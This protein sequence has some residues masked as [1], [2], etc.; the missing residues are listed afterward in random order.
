MVVTNY[1]N[2]GDPP[3]THNWN[4]ECGVYWDQNSPM[5]LT[6]L[7]TPADAQERLIFGTQKNTNEQIWEDSLTLHHHLK[8]VPRL[9]G[10]N[11]I[12]PDVSK[13]ETPLEICLE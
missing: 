4:D 12:C 13:E 8:E 5:Q 2:W 6:Q 10:R 1:S 3:S 11:E 9:V 7:T